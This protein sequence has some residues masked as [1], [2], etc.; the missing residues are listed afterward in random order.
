MIS[1]GTAIMPLFLIQ[2]LVLMSAAIPINAAAE[3][4]I[5]KKVQYEFERDLDGD[6]KACRVV[7]IAVNFPA[8][9]LITMKLVTNGS[10]SLRKVFLS[11]SFDVGDLTIANGVISGASK[12]KLKSASFSSQ[13]FN[14]IGRMNGGPLDDGGV[15]ITT[16]DDETMLALTKSLFAGNYEITFNRQGQATILKS[17]NRSFLL[18]MFSSL[19]MQKLN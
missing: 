10:T 18:S 15:F 3:T 6:A 9:E 5:P 19:M 16:N 2:L 7:M 8:P 12:S 17:L 14:S 13:A 1:Y 11:L 4:L